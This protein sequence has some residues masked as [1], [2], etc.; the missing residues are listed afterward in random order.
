VSGG[1][2]TGVQAVELT[3]ADLKMLDENFGYRPRLEKGPRTSLLDAA[4]LGVVVEAGRD[5][6]V[7]RR[8]SP[9]LALEM[10]GSLDIRK[11]PRAP[12][13]IFGRLEVLPQR[14]YAEQFGR[15]FDLETGS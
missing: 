8:A 12:I 10:S 14:S 1:A 2:A 11:Q 13:E 7:R 15:R 5:T 3:E 4:K 9:R 6:W